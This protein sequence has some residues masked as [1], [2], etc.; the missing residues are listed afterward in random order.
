MSQNPYPYAPAPMA[1]PPRQGWSTVAIVLAVLGGL[2]IGSLVCCGVGAGLLLPAV[3]SARTAARSQVSTYN[4]KQIGLAISNY[5][6]TYRALPPAVVTDANGKPLYSWRVVL[7]PFLGQVPLYQEFHLD[8]AW[9]SPHNVELLSRMPPIYRSLNETS[10]VL[11]DRYN[12]SYVAPVH[13]RAMI[14]NPQRKIREVTDGLSFS[15]AIVE[16][17]DTHTPWTAPDQLTPQQIL[18]ANAGKRLGVLMGDFSVLSVA[19][20]SK[21]NLEQG[22]IIDDGVS[23]DSGERKN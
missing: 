10:M 13:P 7:L 18:Q 19:F 23:F 20:S 9:D 8:E 15:V 22:V 11:P 1:P 2:A 21:L 4:L 6:A 14:G 12:T 5:E 16:S 17:H 3:Q